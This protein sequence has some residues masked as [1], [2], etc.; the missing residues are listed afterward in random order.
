M[1][2][3][4]RETGGGLWTFSARGSH[5]PLPK[6]GPPPEVRHLHGYHAAVSHSGPSLPAACPCLPITTEPQ[7][8]VLVS[9]RPS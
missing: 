5:H 4:R 2:A 1:L 3:V 7:A 8:S 9:A 6:S